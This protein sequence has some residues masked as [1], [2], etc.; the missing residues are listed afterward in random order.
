VHV[1]EVI[2]RKSKRVLGLADDSRLV[3]AIRPA[4]EAML[5]HLYG[6]SGLLRQIDDQHAIRLRPR[7]RL[8][9]ENYEPSVMEFLKK[10]VKLGDVI[11]DVGAHVG[12][13]TMVMARLAGETGHVHAFEP[14]PICRAA[15]IDHLKLNRLS[16]RATVNPLAVG[17]RETT[18]TFYAVGT[19]GISSLSDAHV[20]DTAQRMEVP[21][22]TL[23]LYCESNNIQPSLIKIDV[24]GFEFSVLNGARR[25][26]SECRPNLLIELHPMNWSALGITVNS[27]K[28]QLTG[29][30]YSITGI[31]GQRD[32][33][34]DYG[35][36]AL[37]P[38]PVVSTRSVK[39]DHRTTR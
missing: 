23:D 24:E 2:A 18:T 10:K 25:V 15:L 3:C 12:I 7:D 8:I 17:E 20:D 33:F 21:M 19:S 29:L 4:Y 34:C 31:D 28:G 35:H 9:P 36:V 5:Q 32:L 39:P 22:T 14:N 27:A 6:R 30:D 26:L 16:G 38:E 11:I 1:I 37:E 13:T